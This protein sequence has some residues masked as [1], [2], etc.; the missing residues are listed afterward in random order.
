MKV[1]IAEAARGEDLARL[2]EVTKVGAAV[3]GTYLALAFLIE[4]PQIGLEARVLQVYLSPL[5]VGCTIPAEASGE[6]AV[7]EV[8]ASGHG[9]DD[10][11]GLADSHEVTGAVGG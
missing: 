1:M 2:V 5:G 3:A 6:D 7:E 10:V 9:L 11:G 4:R 8:H